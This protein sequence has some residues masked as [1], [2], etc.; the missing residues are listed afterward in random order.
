MSYVEFLIVFITAILI[1]G[2]IDSIR[3][4]RKK[5]NDKS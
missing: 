4:K 3:E 2:L 1:Y 5:S